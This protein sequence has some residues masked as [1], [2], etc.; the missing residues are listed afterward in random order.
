MLPSLNNVSRASGSR[1]KSRQ[2][3]TSNESI[4]GFS[5]KLS[6]STNNGRRKLS[7]SS[8]ESDLSLEE[9][10]KHATPQQYLKVTIF[11]KISNF[12]S[13]ENL[14]KKFSNAMPKL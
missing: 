11:F 1:L 9:V 10:K 8:F 2:K 14:G 3:L 6:S 12:S 7:K 13:K 4:F 5:E